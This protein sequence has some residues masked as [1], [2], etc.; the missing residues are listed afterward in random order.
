MFKT[1]YRIVTDDYLGFEAQYKIWW[2][3]FWF[4]C[5]INTRRT[6]KES[7]DY[8]A[9]LRKPKPPKCKVVKYVN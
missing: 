7:E 4:Q 8:I 9:I 2:F 6:V 5:S 3:P 1:K